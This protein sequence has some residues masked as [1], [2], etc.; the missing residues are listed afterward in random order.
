MGT[1]LQL[2]HIKLMRCVIAEYVASHQ[3]GQ[4]DDAFDVWKNSLWI[5]LDINSIC[6][7]GGIR[8]ESGRMQLMM[9]YPLELEDVDTG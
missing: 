3:S 7:R 2:L 9:V 4:G 1:C 6:V 5:R 8:K